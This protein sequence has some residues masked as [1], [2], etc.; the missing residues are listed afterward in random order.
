MKIGEC[1]HDG[2]DR[3]PESRGMCHTHYMQWY[4]AQDSEVETL[5]G[6]LDHEQGDPTT[7]ACYWCDMYDD[8]T[9]AAVAWYMGEACCKKH[10][11][12]GQRWAAYALRNMKAGTRAAQ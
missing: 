5:I 8:E 7:F 6:Q 1:S 11:R 2:C 4:R 12:L 3:E 9:N 10:L